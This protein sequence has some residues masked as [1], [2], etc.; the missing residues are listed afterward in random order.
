MVLL[1]RAFR[2]AAAMT[3]MSALMT[4]VPART[5]RSPEQN[6]G[7]GGADAARRRAVDRPKQ[8]RAQQ[9]DAV[10]KVDV[11]V[12]RRDRYADDVC[13]HIGQRREQ[14]LQEPDGIISDAS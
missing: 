2:M 10:A 14:R 11:A 4:K 8:E 7:Q 5:R 13:R 9:H 12:R 6:V 1:P 3:A